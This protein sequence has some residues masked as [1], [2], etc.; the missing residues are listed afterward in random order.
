MYYRFVFFLKKIQKR[1]IL[2][3]YFICMYRKGSERISLIIWKRELGK[4]LMIEDGPR[5]FS[6]LCYVFILYK[7]IYA[8]IICIIS[9]KQLR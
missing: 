1:E 8:C 4:G 7:N 3:R 2:N 6:H 5:R 9:H